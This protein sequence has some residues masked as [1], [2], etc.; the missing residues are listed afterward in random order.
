MSLSKTQSHRLGGLLAVM[1][2][3]TIDLDLIKESIEDGL[4]NTQT[5]N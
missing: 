1:S 5:E 4:L 3:E 2:N